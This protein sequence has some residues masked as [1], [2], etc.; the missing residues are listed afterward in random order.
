MGLGQGQIGFA[1]VKA[2]VICL[3]ASLAGV[4]KQNIASLPWL[5]SSPCLGG[6]VNL[7]LCF[8]SRG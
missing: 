8:V 3:W 6:P 2:K 1:C 5:L 4:Q 7:V